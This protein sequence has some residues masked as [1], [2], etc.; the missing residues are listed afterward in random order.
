[1]CVYVYLYICHL[2]TP[3]YVLWAAHTIIFQKRNTVLCRLKKW[4]AGMQLVYHILILHLSMC[5]CVCVCVCVCVR[6]VTES[7]NVVIVHQLFA[8]DIIN[9]YMYVLEQ[10]IKY[11]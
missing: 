11:I 9:I 10:K 4:A 5:E 8:L 6:E 7:H 1:M 2:H 3:L